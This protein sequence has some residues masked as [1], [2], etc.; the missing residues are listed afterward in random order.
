MKLSHALCG[1]LSAFCASAF[2]PNTAKRLAGPFATHRSAFVQSDEVPT[3]ADVIIIGSGLA[4][5]SCGALLSH[6]NKN[7]TNDS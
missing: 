1:F 7:G 5:L 6:C 2:S 3:E 4:G